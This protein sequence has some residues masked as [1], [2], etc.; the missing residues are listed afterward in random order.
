MVMSKE[1]IR[2]LILLATLIT[3]IGVIVWGISKFDIRN[4]DKQVIIKLD[5][6]SL[7]QQI[8]NSTIEK[9]TVIKQGDLNIPA[10]II[11]VLNSQ[12]TALL[13]QVLHEV[14][15]RYY[16]E[17]VQHTVNADSNIVIDTWDS[18]TENAIY[19][20]KLQYKWLQPVKQT[21]TIIN[22]RNKLYVGASVEAGQNG[23]YAISPEL[24]F[25]MK[26]GTMVGLGY[27]AYNLATGQDKYSFRVSV[28]Q[29]I[30]FRK[31]K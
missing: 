22:E 17:R 25:A 31:R 21:T 28:A 3:F 6:D 7:P 16:E 10:P 14:L 13:K 9:P 23:L 11:N 24:S 20:R 30:S 4:Y 19:G 12:D 8:N 5:Y 15:A 29:K 1:N 27:N 26:K 2:F 18:L